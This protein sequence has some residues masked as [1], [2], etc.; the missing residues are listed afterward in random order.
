MSDKI[1]ETTSIELER[2]L[3]VMRD[4]SALARE[5][6]VSR[7]YINAM[8]FHGFRMPG[9]KASIRMARSFL[10]ACGSFKVRKVTKPSQD[11]ST[12]QDA[13]SDKS[14]ALPQK[15]ALHTP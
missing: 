12:P 15:H 4:T 7:D 10:E 14:H 1:T 2:Y 8:K 9:G 5:L 11:P 6:N 3:T 13:S